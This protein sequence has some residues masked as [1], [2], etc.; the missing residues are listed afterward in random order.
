MVWSQGGADYTCQPFSG[1]QVLE[2][3]YGVL[4]ALLYL[5]LTRVIW[6]SHADLSG[7]VRVL[8]S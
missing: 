7:P 3:W 2:F 8:T 6:S 5:L 1:A 4:E